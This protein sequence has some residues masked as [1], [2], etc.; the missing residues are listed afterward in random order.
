M[1]LFE[2]GAC[3]YCLIG[4]LIRN[5]VG[6]AVEDAQRRIAE[7]PFERVR[8]DQQLGVTKPSLAAIF[9]FSSHWC[10]GR[11]TVQA[12]WQRRASRGQPLIP[13]PVLLIIKLLTALNVLHHLPVRLLPRP[14]LCSSIVA[15][16]LALVCSHAIHQLVSGISPCRR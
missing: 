5:A 14:S 8:F 1:P 3:G 6:R 2:F 15:I 16:P 4:G 9:A 10:P 7:L 13:L 12:D 11:K